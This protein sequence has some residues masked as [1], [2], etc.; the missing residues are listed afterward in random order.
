MGNRGKGDDHDGQSMMRHRSSKNQKLLYCLTGTCV[1]LLT[2]CGEVPCEGFSSSSA[3]SRLPEPG[4]INVSIDGSDSMRGFA[5]VNDS[6]FQSTL[7]ELDNTLGISPALGYSKSKTVVARIGREADPSN[8]FYRKE[9][10]SVLAARRPEFFEAKPGSWPKVSSMIERFVTKDP[11][12]VDILIS[13][14]EPDDASIKQVVSA[15]MSKLENKPTTTGWWPWGKKKH[16]GNQLVIVGIRSQFNGGVFPTVQGNFKSFPYIGLRPFYIV[17]LGPV[18]KVEMVVERLARNKSLSQELQLSRFSLDPDSGQTAFL[19]Q[20]DSRLLPN[21]CLSPVYTLSQGLSGRLQVQEPKRW[22][23]AVRSKLCSDHNVGIRFQTSELSGF[24]QSTITD[25]TF[26]I[27]P[28]ADIKTLTMSHEGLTLEVRFPS[29]K[30]VTNIMNI[31]ADAAKIDQLIWAEWS[32]SG[33][34]LEGD[35][36][37]R[38]LPLI[39][40]LRSETDQ[41]AEKEYGTRYSPVRMCAAVKG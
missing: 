36:T 40:S 26:F 1:L 2:G 12:S 38:L 11:T 41:Y 9:V 35:K 21:S 17:A 7:E 22:I 33:T 24:G 23:L 10:S 13:D 15:I 28:N 6:A 31:S 27:S 18:E 16:S 20:S 5:T 4:I 34:R 3:Q 8:K 37:Q 29:V 39:Q 30:S 19:S 25:P 32:T 14:L